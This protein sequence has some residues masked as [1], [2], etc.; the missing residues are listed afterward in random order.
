MLVE[1]A[2]FKLAAGAVQVVRLRVRM[3]CTTKRKVMIRIGTK[4]AVAE[5]PPF[6]LE[7]ELS[8][9]LDFDELRMYERIGEGSFG[10]VYRGA[11]RKQPV[12][13]KLLR[14][15]KFNKDELE[16]LRGEAKFLSQLRHK[17]SFCVTD[18]CF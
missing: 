7:S 18:A 16:E 12:A 13:I 3:L 15:Q 1:P 8:T 14:Q 17:V 9:V 2:Q 10:V 11:W 5:L 6:K 4:H